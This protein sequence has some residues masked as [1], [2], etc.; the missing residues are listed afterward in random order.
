M[1]ARAGARARILGSWS[2]CPPGP[3]AVGPLGPREIGESAQARNVFVLRGLLSFTGSA[4]ACEE[5][6]ATLTLPNGRR[7]VTKICNHPDCED[8][9][10]VTYR[11]GGGR[12]RKY[13]TEHRST[14]YAMIR[15]RHY[16]ELKTSGFPPCCQEAGRKCP[17]HLSIPKPHM[18]YRPSK[19]ERSAIGELIDVWGHVSIWR[20]RDSRVLSGINVW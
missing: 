6:T 3:V 17:Q 7:K 11:P 18:A 13:C 14:K 12:P 20:G 2:L 9:F 8:A 4:S 1:F 19:D 16:P 5:T 10:T 15:N